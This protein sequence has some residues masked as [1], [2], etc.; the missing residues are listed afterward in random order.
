MACSTIISKRRCSS[1]VY[2]SL[3][4]CSCGQLKTNKD[5]LKSMSMGMFAPKG[6]IRFAFGDPIKTN[7]TLAEN[8]EQRNKY[9]RNIAEM[10]DEQIYKNFKLWPSNYV[11]YDMLMQEHRFKDKY[12]AEEQ[13]RFEIMV[14]Q[15]MVN[16]DYPITDLQERFLKVYANPVINKLKVTKL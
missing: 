6:R 5:D 16:I 13:R 10:I 11:A 8:N 2:L 9:I 1:A 15:A 4:R 14:E 7:F 12:T 3:K